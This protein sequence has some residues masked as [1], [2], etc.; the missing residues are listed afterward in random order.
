MTSSNR[1]PDGTITLPDHLREGLDLLFVGLNPS[2]YS[3]E[4]GHY[5]ANPRNRFWAA[6]NLSGLVD[7]KLDAANDATLL[8]DGIGFTDVAKR[9]TAMG[10]GLRA[11]DFRRWAPVLREKILKFAPK[12]VCFHGMMAYK[13]YLQHGE[14]A[15]EDP[16][17]G[18]QER[19]IGVSKV[20]VVPNPSPANAK[21][22]LDD[23][24]AW[25][26][27]LREASRQ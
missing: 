1:L 26:G 7:R 27:R 12:L 10:S 20:F 23:L 2:Q 15:K 9:P 18:L 4:V 21:Y 6:F 25:Y 22:S 3:A 5:F 19:S 17:L 14:G 16:Q 13:A 11:A 24:A 8:A